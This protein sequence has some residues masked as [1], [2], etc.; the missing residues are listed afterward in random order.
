M[1]WPRSDKM[2]R[3]LGP[4][5]EL[6][7]KAAAA[8]RHSYEHGRLPQK[9]L[10]RPVISVGAI[11]VGGSGKTPLVS[12]I[13]G[14]FSSNRHLVILSR[15]YGRKDESSYVALPQGARLDEDAARFFG[16]EP[17]ML[18]KRFDNI[19]IFLG[20]ERFQAGM[21]ALRHGPV[22]AFLL[23]DGFQH[24][25][26]HR[27]F[28]LVTLDASEDPR[29]LMELPVGTLREPLDA[30]SRAHAFVFQH[31][32]PDGQHRIDLEWLRGVNA[33]ATV[34]KACYEIESLRD[35]RTG[36]ILERE[37]MHNAPLFL[38]S[39]IARPEKIASLLQMESVSLVGNRYFSDHHRFSGK[40]LRNVEEEAI[41]AGAEALLTTEK[42]A[43][44]LRWS[45][46]RGLPIFVLCIRIRFLEGET[47][48]MQR[49][50]E[51]IGVR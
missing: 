8:R 28:E 50:G 23:D 51:V 42:D 15:G 36:A 13:Y 10:P 18:A 21:N 4:L 19:P 49:I 9:Q 48:L 34:A 5:A 20:P 14:K 35:G 22:D 24:Y 37:T 31:C 27:D 25:E 43:A 44:R 29:N 41:Q 46:L 7:G 26:L 16:D 40:E 33:K 17:V 30:L 45:R 12:H 47:E 39:G 6:Y 11:T 3:W 38:F 2:K 1:R 32:T